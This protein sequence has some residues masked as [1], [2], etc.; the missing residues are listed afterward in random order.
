MRN[1]LNT[2]LLLVAILVLAQPLTSQNSDVRRQDGNQ[3]LK[4]CTQVI[5]SVD[6]ESLDDLQSMDAMYCLGYISG[7][8]NSHL[9]VTS[10]AKIRTLFCTPKAGIPLRGLQGGQGA[11]IIV[12]WLNDHPEKLHLEKDILTLAALI[13]A[14]PC[15]TDD[16]E[17]VQ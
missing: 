13:N 11:R 15:Q 5:R 8:L 1:N 14:F 6:G 17:K 10:I 2:V 12:K 3:F 9:L 4:E 7:F 16:P